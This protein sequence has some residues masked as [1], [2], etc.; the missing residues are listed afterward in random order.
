MCGARGF[1]ILIC[2]FMSVAAYAS[3]ECSMYKAEPVRKQHGMVDRLCIVNHQAEDPDVQKPDNKERLHKA[4]TI[5][6]ATYFVANL[7]MLLQ[8]KYGNVDPKSYFH[9][10]FVQKNTWINY[11]LPRII[12]NMVQ[13]AAFAYNLVQIALEA[14]LLRTILKFSLLCATG[15]MAD[16]LE[17]TALWLRRVILGG[18]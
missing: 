6:V 9:K 7:Y 12:A 13:H 16:L 11:L 15:D 5:F 17:K 8:E 18:E 2:I 1:L 14:A 10:I 3:N 4:I